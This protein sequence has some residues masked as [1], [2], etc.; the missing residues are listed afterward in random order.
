M[1]SKIGFMRDKDYFGAVSISF[2][3]NL[4][5]FL[6]FRKRDFIRI[7]NYTMESDSSYQ[8]Q[9]MVESYGL[10]IKI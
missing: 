5:K 3:K 9:T 10:K 4:L 7:R 8:L 1:I 2:H 6:S